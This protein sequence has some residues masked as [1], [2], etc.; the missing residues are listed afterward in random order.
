[1]PYSEEFVTG[2][3]YDPIYWQAYISETAHAPCL[4]GALIVDD[5]SCS[6]QE[7]AAIQ[8]DLFILGATNNN[9]EHD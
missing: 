9:G 1:V 7:H 6:M 5:A 4:I 2:F 3:N 8:P